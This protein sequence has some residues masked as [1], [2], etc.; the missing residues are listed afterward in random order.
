MQLYSTCVHT[1]LSG[2]VFLLA[3]MHAPKAEVQLED[4]RLLMLY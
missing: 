4:I 2:S 1:Q 3:L